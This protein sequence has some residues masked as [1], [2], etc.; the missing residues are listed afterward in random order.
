MKY[1]TKDSGNVHKIFHISDIHI[2]LFQRMEEYQYVFSLLYDE[3]RKSK[4]GAENIIVVTGDIVH[5]K[6]ELSP[7]C[8]MLTF[9]FLSSL[10]K[11]FPTFVIAGNHDA[12]LNNRHRIDTL[13]SIL[14]QRETNNLYYLKNTDIFNYKNL[15]FYV[16]SLLDD[17][18]IDMTN[19]CA[20]DGVHV[21]LFH[22]G[23][24][25]WKNANGY[26]SDH[27]EKYIQ[28]FS[29]MDYVLLGDIHMF[30]YM[31]TVKPVC[32]YAGSL[33]SQ[34]FGETDLDHGVLIWNLE[35]KTQNFVRIEN[36][37]RF[38]DMYILPENHVKTDGEIISMDEICLP[39]F[40]Q[41]RVF[42][43]EDEI[44]SKGCF[45]T[46]KSRHK[47][48]NFHFHSNANK[49]IDR[50][51]SLSIQDDV[52][53]LKTYITKH[54]P[55]AYQDEMYTFLLEKWHSQ[56]MMNLSVKWEIKKIC[57][58][59]LFGY[60]AN[61]YIDLSNNN[62]GI[63]GIFGNNSFG[64][65]TIIDII[66]LLLFDKV[67]RL[68]HGQTIPKEVIHE[69]ESSAN[70]YITIK[71]GNETYRIEKHFQRQKNEKIKQTTKVFHIDCNNISVEMTGEQRKKTNRFIEQIV[72]KYDIFIYINSYLQQK[73]N[74][75]RDMTGSQKK[76]FLNELYGYHW[77]SQLE[78]DE[79]DVLKELELEFKLMEKKIGP[80]D[81]VSDEKL[82]NFTVL[83]EKKKKNV[84]LV[85][86]DKEKL[87]YEIKFSED[88]FS[89]E[90]ARI[91]NERAILMDDFSRFQNEMAEMTNFKNQW[92]DHVL[93]DHWKD[94]H[95][96]EF[97]QKWNPKVV[98]KQDWSLFWDKIS[99]HQYSNVSEIEKTREQ[100]CQ[101]LKRHDNSVIE[102]NT[103]KLSLFPTDQFEKISEE[104]KRNE[105]KLMDYEQK[106]Q[107]LLNQIYSP[108]E[109]LTECD[110]LSEKQHEFETKTE[111]LH[112]KINECQTKLKQFESIEEFVKKE[113][114][115]EFIRLHDCYRDDEIY[116]KYSPFTKGKFESWNSFY[117]NF[118]NY[119]TK[120]IKTVRDDLSMINDEIDQL[121]SEK[122]E[123]SKGEL[124]SN[125]KLESCRKTVAK[126][127]L[128]TPAF[129]W[130]E[131]DSDYLQNLESVESQVFFMKS[132]IS[133]IE[134]TLSNL[135]FR[136]NPKCSVCLN[137]NEY[138]LKQD[139]KKLLVSKKKEIQIAKEILLEKQ[140]YF[141]KKINFFGF[142]T[143]D[144]IMSDTIRKQKFKRESE[145]EQEKKFEL[146][147]IQALETIHNHENHVAYQQKKNEIHQAKNKREKLLKQY[148]TMIYF[149]EA[150]SLIEYIHIQWENIRHLPSSM[151]ILKES[152]EN[153]H[154]LFH[155][156]HNILVELKKEL[157][158]ENARWTENKTT[159]EKD[160]GY[161]EEID[162]MKSW[163]NDFEI[164]KQWVEEQKKNLKKK[165]QMENLE[166]IEQLEK[167]EYFL[168]MYHD[169]KTAIKYLL[170]LWDSPDLWDT[171]M[172]EI[173]K[174]MRKSTET[175]S[176]CEIYLEKNK[177]EQKSL[178]KQTQT[179][180]KQWEK[181]QVLL[182]QIHDYDIIKKEIL[183]EIQEIEKQFFEEKIE[184]ERKKQVILE[185]TMLRKTLYQLEEKIKRQKILCQILE[186]DGIP[187]FLLQ[188]KMKIMERQMN[189]LVGPF[190][191]KKSIH[192]FINEK[193]I[194]FGVVSSSSPQKLCNIYGG[195]ESFIIEL[196]VKL[197][198]SKYSI[199]PRSNFFIIDEGISVLDKQNVANISTLF[200][201]LS[202][203]V[204]NVFLISHLPQ[205]QDF[206]DQS[207]F[208][209]KP[210]NKSLVQFKNS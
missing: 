155:S 190:L 164:K 181:D 136:P 132:E 108:L 26:V 40:G 204:T 133:M 102:I 178:E 62:G 11:I 162:K 186:K 173:E 88:T 39:N 78:K 46:I 200:Q 6:N 147:K 24:R 45:E 106:Q 182:Q 37:Y 33:I 47:N 171:E 116:G 145:K 195:M 137:N 4:Y 95:Q 69:D 163:I 193:T 142:E 119:N 9:D 42:S 68:S 22:G 60:G 111:S 158:I 203:L 150:K 114:S 124:V 156:Y 8:D 122:S 43:S 30:Q 29:A 105:K 169:S 99:E 140:S 174:T 183:V 131:K 160:Y 110:F 151:E 75:F 168:K 10:S 80:V 35:D 141:K 172:D 71:I 14:H 38:Q 198:F 41:I 59:N 152:I 65:S 166:K 15:Y 87:L 194:E 153:Y 76:K 199:L 123:I 180:T 27:G 157:T 175:L 3:L 149:V 167:K 96:T 57:F 115:S 107:K 66:S 205:I 121:Q 72:G 127:H 179:I 48:R 97:F 126:K 113:N 91:E 146:D 7:E 54:V 98:S 44:Y 16:D 53:S 118:T 148:N 93:V 32:A 31:S 197:T 104:I 201:F 49:M 170:V 139:R 120:C 2:R 129:L 176:K 187:L 196:V 5:S 94:V 52:N 177:N 134:S 90:M 77:F 82:Q 92:T 207:I 70:G 159:I 12:L 103:E 117:N 19:R 184:L 50:K 13:S 36:P 17:D 210:N 189:E 81:T 51:E 209:T 64:K 25:G 85:D 56:E 23:I 191:P 34:N 74:S 20:N 138:K 86:A 73:E 208:I 63:I 84:V 83:L 125:A 128:P 143:M 154:S 101:F 144:I 61:N 135:T 89:K 1:L 112:Q 165:K 55:K 79:K 185:Q 109:K 202:N 100:L 130:T 206:V 67:T 192:F 161:L 21:A 28:D 58:S 18:S 188:K